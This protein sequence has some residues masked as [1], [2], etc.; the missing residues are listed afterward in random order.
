M[1]QEHVDEKSALI[2]ISGATLS[3][4]ISHSFSG[5]CDVHTVSLRSPI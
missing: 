3:V 4:F 1:T 2:S 5:S